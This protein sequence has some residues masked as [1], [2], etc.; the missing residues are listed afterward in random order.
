MRPEREEGRRSG[1]YIHSMGNDPLVGRKLLSLLHEAGARPVRNEWL[2]FGSCTG[3]EHF[4]ALCDNFAGVLME[5]RERMLRDGHATTG[6]FDAAM[7]EFE[8]WRRRP[9]AGIW[10]GRCWAEGIRSTSTG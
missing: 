3:D 2:F 1:D 8:A 4:P 10:Y 6:A 5:A 9:D 7:G